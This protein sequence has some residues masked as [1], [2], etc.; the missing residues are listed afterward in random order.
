MSKNLGAQTPFLAFAVAAIAFFFTPAALAD[1]ITYDF[2]VDVTTGALSGTATSGSFSYDSNSIVLGGGA[3]NAAGL[4]TALDFTFNGITYNANTAN[5]GFLSFDAAGNL[6]GA[7][8]G[9]DCWAG[10]CYVAA[11]T[12]YWYA[13][14][15][16]F[17]FAS[18]TSNDAYH[19]N[20]T[21]A[22]AVAIPEPGTPELFGLGALMI[23]LLVGLR[24]RMG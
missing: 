19:G 12:D 4:L 14:N 11:G 23:G 6:T 9:N 8:F 7:K 20:V 24:R 2:T 21:Y 5:T 18:L 16:D 15:G 1:T 13:F 22:H 10:N 17:L 3:N